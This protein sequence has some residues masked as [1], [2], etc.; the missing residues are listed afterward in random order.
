MNVIK[1]ILCVML[2]LGMVVSCSKEQTEEPTLE[3]ALELS[4]LG[5]EEVNSQELP[6]KIKE[7]LRNSNAN[8]NK[9]L[10]GSLQYVSHKVL[11]KA[12]SD[13]ALENV[14][15]M[16]AQDAS[17]VAIGDLAQPET[18]SI[19]TLKQV[20]KTSNINRKNVVKN[21]ARK[22]V[23]KGDIVMELTWEYQGEKITTIALGNEEGISWDNMLSGIFLTEK[24]AISEDSDVKGTNETARYRSWSESGYKWTFRYAWGAYRGEMFYAV[25]V[26]Y[27]LDTREVILVD[28]RDGANIGWGSGISESAVI[29]RGRDY[30]QC[31][32]ALGVATSG[33]SITFD[34]GNFKVNSNYGGTFV[35]NGTDV[36]YVPNRRY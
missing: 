19:K 31:R 22:T 17:I 6:F 23:D 10:G 25:R 9:Y 36:A 29:G 26:T 16:S 35:R 12:A 1:K 18:V 13:K 7:Q 24:E 32:Y 4:E 20:Q 2:V 15:S 14:I 8:F 34:R 11:G 30:G 33:G 27:D 3:N 28:T 21:L 5:L